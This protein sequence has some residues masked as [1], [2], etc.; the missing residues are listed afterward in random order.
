[1]KLA[2]LSVRRHVL[3]FM[4]SAVLVLFG[5]VAYQRIGVDRFPRIEFPVISITTV[6]PGANPDV[7]DSSITNII[8]TAVNSVPGIDNIQSRSSPSVSNVAITFN[9]S[10]DV[11][12]AF[13]E[14]QAKVNQVLRQLPEDADPPV[15]L[16]VE[17]GASAVMWLALQGDR[18]TQQLNQ[19]ARQ[20][21]KKRL[22]TV[23]GVGQV[24]IGGERRRNIR[25]NLDLDRMAGLGVTAQDVRNAFRAE[26][27]QLPGGFLVSGPGESLIKLDLEY[28]SPEALGDLIVRY[29]EGAPV[30]LRDVGTVED[31][32]ADDRQVV[33]FDGKPT[34]GIGIVKVSNYN[35]VRLV[36]DI[37]ER[38]DTQIIPQLPAG[39]TLTTSIDDSAPI[40]KIVSALEDHLV[41]GT[42]LAGLVVWFFLRS[43]RSTLI[44]STAIPVSLLGAIA[45]MYFLGYT[46]NQMSLLGLLLLIGVVVDDAIVVLENVYRRLEE[47]PA[48]D[49]RT[50][51]IEGTEQVGFAVIAASLTL[52][53]I[54]GSVLFLEGIVARFFQSF[55]V[56]VTVGVLVSLFVS[57]TLTPML[58]SRFLEP[59]TKHGAV[60]RAL[61]RLLDGLDALYRRLLGWVLAHRV[62]VVLATVAV[63]LSSGFFFAR[64]GKDFIPEEDDARFTV[65]FRAPLGTSRYGMEELL[66]QVDETIRRHPEVRSVFIGIGFGGVSQVNSGMAFVNMVPREERDISQRQFLGRLQAE[67]SQIPGVLAFASV[68]SPIGGMRGEMLQFSVVGPE[69]ASVASLSRELAKRLGQDPGL[70][71]IDLDLQLDLPQIRL[72]VDRVRAADL[73]LTGADVAYAVNMLAGG[74]DIAK[75]N[76]EPGDGDRYDIRVKA[77]DGEIVS[78][79]DLRRIFLR[80]PR[81]QMVRLDTVATAVDVVGPAVINRY[82]LQYSANF[83]TN[84]TLPLG[85][86]VTRVRA[87]AAELLP[88]GYSMELQGRAREFARTSGY[89]RLALM[90]ALALVYIVLASQFNS[91]LQPLIVMTAQPLAVVGGLFAL[92]VTGTTLNMISMIGLILL[93]GLVAKNSILLVDLTNQLRE[94]GRAVDAALAE[95]CPVRLRPVLMTSLTVILALAPAALGLGAGADTNGPMAIAVIGGMVSSTLLTLVVV[96]AVYSLVEQGLSRLRRRPA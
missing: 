92:W 7:V 11:D 45:A 74:V 12:V 8:E 36:D 3:A 76:D 87:A 40:R 38:L 37:R 75:Y 52:V 71:R 18:T 32:L 90:L 24:I 46:F 29:A 51:A 26:H 88:P 1:V 60:Y 2:E 54:F 73:G 58:C 42:V 48:L 79:D 77:A 6:L 70:G 93:M 83:Y 59:S 61:D 14:V 28:H 91:F 82:G 67:L 15:V 81:G 20:V 50:A 80:T 19:Y 57:L 68:P 69:L 85:E 25:V 96:P 94:S 44:I 49:R 89:V 65:N 66:T 5:L 34:V 27:V 47:N 16:K 55:A 56:V 53:S 39:L 41:E 31:G 13:S 63:V 62:T 22:E 64:V 21:I 10:K 4:A 78:A 17:V 33:R 86:A 72:E 95:A 30:R 84:P 23:D 43:F 35:T 9:L